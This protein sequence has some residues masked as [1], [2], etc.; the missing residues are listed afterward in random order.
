MKI[1]D[2]C[3]RGFRYEI[4]GGCGLFQAESLQKS[5]MVRHCFTSR[6][7]GVSEPPFDTLNMGLRRADKRENLMENYR[8]VCEAMNFPMERLTLVNYNHGTGVATATLEDAGRGVFREDFPFECD[9]ITTNQRGL[10]LVTLHADCLPVF[11]LD[12]KKHAIGLCHAGW[13]GVAAKTPVKTLENMKRRYGTEPGDVVAAV[14]PGISQCCF[15][16]DEPV[17]KIFRDTFGPE[18]M[19]ENGV[20][21]NVD[22]Y[23]CCARQLI[24]AGIRI[25]NLTVADQ[26]TCCDPE[27]R[28][29]TVRKEKETG[30]MAGMM[31]LL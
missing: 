22:L 9:G 29:F 12:E 30:A 7:G 17:A 27:R 21:S 8:R 31:E 25:E 16:V 28:F 13:R 5:G 11:L 2:E 6:I 19:I 1:T 24:E 4:I 3:K 20:K 10:V 18:I 14:G 23:E 26:C 15:E